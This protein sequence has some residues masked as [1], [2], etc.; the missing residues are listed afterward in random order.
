MSDQKLE[1]DIRRLLLE[2]VERRMHA[3]DLNSPPSASPSSHHQA[4]MR[5][6]LRDPLKWAR[7]RAR[8]VWLTVLRRAAV[9]LLA[10]LLGLGAV[11]FSIPSARAAMVR[12]FIEWRDTTHWAYRY[13]GEAPATDISKYTISA[14]PEGFEETKRQEHPTSVSVVYENSAGAVIYLDYHYMFEGTFTFYE[15]ENSDIY[16]VE[17]NHMYGQY[18]ASQLPGAF[19]GIT[20]INEEANIQFDITGA[21]ERDSIIHMAESVSLLKTPK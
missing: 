2:S 21:F 19:N 9:F 5:A 11:V 20:W 8:P 13:T 1:A 17:I 6:M 10:L 7:R 4:Q 12:W 18:T 3:I 14:L 15:G 16:D